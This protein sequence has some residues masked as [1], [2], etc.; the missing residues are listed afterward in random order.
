[1]LEHIRKAGERSAALTRQL[2]A[3]SR[4]QVLAPVVLDLNDLVVNLEKMLLRLIGEDI[5]LTLNLDPAL[6]AI[7]IDP[8]QLEQVLVNLIVN[9]RDAMPTGGRLNLT[10]ANV[11]VSAE[12]AWHNPDA[13]EGLYSLLSV[14]DSGHGMD[15][16]TR[17]RVFEPFFTT[18]EVGK[19]TGLGLSTAYGVITQSGGFIDIESQP[20]KGAQFKVHLPSVAQSAA[21]Q[22][23]RL[24]MGDM[25]RGTET[26]LLVEDENDVRDLAHFVLR[27]CGYQVLEASNAGE[28]FMRCEKHQAVIDLL[29][30][31]VVMPQF[32]G[33]EL[34]ERL[35]PLRPAM[36]VLY[37]VG[38][39]RRRRA[40]PRPGERQ[41]AV[42]TEALHP[43]SPGSKGARGA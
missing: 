11:E 23:K 34:A 3:F 18:K 41:S 25:P 21:V 6:R 1:M 22:K 33:R 36:K 17:T 27:Q 9:A 16:A 26:V 12:R 2:L 13:R 10:T 8:G 37:M 31:D 32:S 4:K 40:A 7:K 28:A 19:G 38:L 43:A 14:R 30:T 42:L 29:L 35:Q 15:T 39:H 24:S 5:T 20:G